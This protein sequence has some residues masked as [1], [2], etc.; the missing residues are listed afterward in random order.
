MARG[1]T[2]PEGPEAAAAARRHVSAVGAGRPDLD[3]AL[4]VVSELCSNALRHGDPP[5]ELR[6]WAEGGTLRVE[7]ENR[8]RGGGSE[9]LSAPRAMPDPDATR[10][11]GLAIVQRLAA[12]WGWKDDAGRTTVWAELRQPD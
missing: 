6:V 7:I 8:S 11:R 5:R 1:W 2:L 12:D 9:A 4:L 3:D 10:G